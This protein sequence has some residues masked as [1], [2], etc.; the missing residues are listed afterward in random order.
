MIHEGIRGIVS[1]EECVGEVQ[2]AGTNQPEDGKATVLNNLGA[3][4]EDRLQSLAP[5][6]EQKRNAVLREKIDLRFDGHAAVQTP[7]EAAAEAGE[8]LPLQG[9]VVFANSGILRTQLKT[10]IQILRIYV[11][12]GDQEEQTYP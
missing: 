8:V 11:C 1:G 4:T 10:G 7:V 5:L 2:Q 3:D 12:R 6:Y 9:V